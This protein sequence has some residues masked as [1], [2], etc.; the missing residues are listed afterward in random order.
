MKKTFKKNDEEFQIFNEFWHIT[1][2]YYEPESSDEYWVSFINTL[3]DFSNKH[4]DSLL[5]HWMV[6]MLMDLMEDKYKTDKS[7][8]YAKLIKK[9]NCAYKSFLKTADTK[10]KEL[11]KDI[12]EANK[13]STEK[14]L[15][16]AAIR[17]AAIN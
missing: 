14:E 3:D 5:C 13:N 2:E 1:Q 7:A 17:A 9:V 16:L 8:A 11:L 4:P 10:D 6:L 15:I 12:L